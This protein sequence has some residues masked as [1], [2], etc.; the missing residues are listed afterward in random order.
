MEGK[1]EGKVVT[2]EIKTGIGAGTVFQATLG[3]SNMGVWTSAEEAEAYVKKFSPTAK[4][5][6]GTPSDIV[7][8]PQD[9]YYIQPRTLFTSDV[10]RALDLGVLLG[11]K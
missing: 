4:Q 2:P 5:V 1:M 6:E 3:N 8:L 9:Q 10:R 7:D 11:K